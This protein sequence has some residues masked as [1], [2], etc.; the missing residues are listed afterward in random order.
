M[1]MELRADMGGYNKRHDLPPLT[2]TLPPPEAC[3]GGAR[4]MSKESIVDGKEEG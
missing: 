3:M 1:G 4:R 2:N